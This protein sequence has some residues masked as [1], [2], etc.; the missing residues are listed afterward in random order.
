MCV[1][2]YSFTYMTMICHLISIFLLFVDHG[3]L[4][5]PE[6]VLINMWRSGG[7]SC[8]NRG[9]HEPMAV[10]L[11]VHAPSMTKLVFFGDVHRSPSNLLVNIDLESSQTASYTMGHIFGLCWIGFSGN[12]QV[13]PGLWD[14]GC[15]MRMTM[16][17]RYND[18]S[19]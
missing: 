1:C 19:F 4:V 15:M 9:P 10:G 5:D 17:A 8:S 3:F 2:V 13:G 14:R 7:S 16:A 6:L 18:C 12:G 11:S